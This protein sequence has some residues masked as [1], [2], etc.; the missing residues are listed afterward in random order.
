MLVG[1]NFGNERHIIGLN[2][3]KSIENPKSIDNDSRLFVAFLF[4]LYC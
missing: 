3:Q 4:A 1:A 2:F